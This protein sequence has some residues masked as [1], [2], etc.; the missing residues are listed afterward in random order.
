MATDQKTN[1]TMQEAQR[2]AQDVQ[3]TLTT[4]GRRVWLAG[5]GA[6][7]EV[8]QQGSDLFDR[9]V[10]QG[11]GF[12]R[13]RRQE[14]HEL[15][16]EAKGRQAEVQRR[17]KERGE[18]VEETLAKV[19]SGTIGRI[20]VLTR[21]EL[22]TL[23]KNLDGLA[24]KVD[25]LALKLDQQRRGAQAEVATNGDVPAGEAPIAADETVYHVVPREEGWAV[26][27]E[28]SE[29]A[30]S[31]HDTKKEAVEAGRDVA[32]RHEPSRLIVHKQDRSVQE[33]FAYGQ[34]A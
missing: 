7:A 34:E 8:Q 22:T 11:E 9:L 18:G 24:V 20:G 33:A 13:Q 26:T 15:V 21:G 30:T 10:E 29:Q 19:L 2:F 1:G 4:T 5:L 25:T 14:F 27:K 17:V 12:E 23:A 28:G 16:E 3:E 6:L 32:K 31:L